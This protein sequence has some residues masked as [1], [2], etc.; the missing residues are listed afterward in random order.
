MNLRTTF[1]TL[2]LGTALA[3]TAAQPRY[4]FYFIGDGM[5]VGAAMAGQTYNSVALG[6]TDRLLMT[7]FPIAGMVE[8]YSAN[9]RV[10]DSAAAGTALATG[11]KTRNSMIGVTPD[12]VPVNSIAKILHDDGWGVALVTT[13]SPDDAT[14]AAFYAHVPYRRMYY[15][16]GR[17]AA[18]SGYEFIAG[19]DWRGLEDKDTKEPTGLL[20]Y[21]KS[22][23]VD[24]VTSTA[25]A[26][27]SKSR[28]VF[29]YSETPFY[30]DNA[31]FTIDSVETAL[32]LPDMTA[33]AI[34]HMMR[35]SP[36]RF[37]MMVE[38]G[39]IDH[40]AHGN[41]GP[42]V[43]VEVYNFNE[44]LRHAYDFYLQHPHETLIVVTA[45]HETGGMSIGNGA[46]GYRSYMQCI[47]LQR[48]SK[49]MFSDKVW[50]MTQLPQDQ[51]PTWEEF[52]AFIVENTGL[53]NGLRIK[54]EQEEA[55]HEQFVKT[56]ET[57]D[58]APDQETLYS[59]FN[60]LTK[61]IF[62]IVNENMGFGWTTTG[63]SGNPVPLYAIG[64][65]MEILG[66]LNDNTEIKPKLLE[67]IQH[68]R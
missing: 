16:I 64:E 22:H 39:N 66:N 44:A 54:P 6:N 14:P 27:D 29:L 1:A 21:I 46:N 51:K 4:V 19:S 13:S 43:A 31:G 68:T 45:D 60:G 32:K 59:T 34:D 26:R 57:G 49:D 47:P 23:D 50:N 42:G 40:V 36:D 7:Q 35:V 11:H 20:E 48:M 56:F 41:D 24:L 38:G 55:I 63:H 65:G 61:T 37:F 25:A 10:T 52:K 15:E 17:Q 62:D 2:L 28:R 5:G 18:E 33:T 67:I 53:W 58:S 3:L 8:T 12:S 30:S 9:R